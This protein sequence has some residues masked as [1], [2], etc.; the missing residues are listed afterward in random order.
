MKLPLLASL[1][2]ALAVVCAPPVRAAAVDCPS[3]ESLAPLLGTDGLFLGE[4]HGSAEVPALM[5]CLVRR[6]TEDFAGRRPLWVTLELQPAALEPSATTWRT[7]FQ[8]GRTSEAMLKLVQ[9]LKLL[10]AQGRLTLAGFMPSDPPQDAADYERAMARELDR[11]PADAFVLALGGNIHARKSVGAARFS[12]QAVAPAGSLLRRHMT[13]VL[14]GH[15]QPS[16]AWICM[17]VCGPQ[18]LGPSAEARDRGT[19]LHRL[20]DPDYDYLLLLERL[21]ASPP[22]YP[23]SP[24]SEPATAP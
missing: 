13:H 9:A 14:I 12:V 16:Q 15:R 19:G 18:A 5:E 22:A 8:D 2:L 23:A 10:Q 11:P 24:T 1:A 17:P 6:L 4:V 20:D 3:G 7:R 21:T